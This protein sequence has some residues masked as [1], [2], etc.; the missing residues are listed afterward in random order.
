M[1]DTSLTAQAQ[2]LADTYLPAPEPIPDYS[3]LS[4][5]EEALILKLHHDG[6]TQ[7]TIAKQLGCAQS[8]VSRV[9]TDFS[10]TRELAKLRTHNRALD[11]AEAAVNGAIKAASEGKPEAALEIMDRQDVLARKQLDT[12]RGGNV[13]IVIGMPE[14]PAGP[15]PVFDVSPSPF[16][17]ECS[18]IG[19]RK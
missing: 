18:E 3:R 10:D 7:T 19:Q 5:A 16:A 13:N 8:T 12:G 15:K 4:R 1:S 11:I 17:P 14:Q 2:A 9:L 6:Q